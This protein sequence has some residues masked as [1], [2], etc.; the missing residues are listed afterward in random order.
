MNQPSVDNMTF[1]QALAE[2]D[3]IVHELEDGQ[4]GLEDALSH[5]ESGVGLIKRCHAQLRTVEQRI[6]Q[7]AG[8]DAD[9]KPVTESFDHSAT[10][11]TA[12]PPSKPRRKRPDEP[13]I[14]F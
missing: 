13:E 14:L 10:G 6:L 4:L 5:Y 9:G 8:T 1:E 3:R 2:L 11:E 12:K 7:L